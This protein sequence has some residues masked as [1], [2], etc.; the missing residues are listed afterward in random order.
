MGFPLKLLAPGERL[1]LVLRPHA[2]VLVAPVLVLLITAPV[3]A[4]LAGLVPDGSAQP[5]M[6]LAVAAVGLVV[7][8]HWTLWPFLTWWNTIYAI[9]DRR[10]VLRE[11]VFNRT[12][13][14]MPLSRLND[15]KFSHNVVE[16]VLGCGTLVV[17]SAGE[18]GQLVLD[19]IPRVEQ[20]QRTLYRLSDE[21]RGVGDDSVVDEY[22]EFDD[23]A[24][25]DADPDA[26]SGPDNATKV[27][28]GRRRRGLT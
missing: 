19:D 9:T 4:Y 14:D 25:P 18:I 3:T 21:V 13:H 22:D 6:R 23:D 12:G 17:E 27:L 26:D 7:V 5:W 16:R 1:V 15:V 11:G 8:G 2:K 10:L 24:D 28:R 20:V